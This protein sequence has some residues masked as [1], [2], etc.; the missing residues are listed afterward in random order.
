MLHKNNIVSVVISLIIS[1]G[2]LVTALSL[3]VEYLI[4]FAANSYYANVLVPFS[5]SNQSKMEQEDALVNYYATKKTQLIE[6]LR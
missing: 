6:V 1:F 2:Y 3:W 4:F 5:I